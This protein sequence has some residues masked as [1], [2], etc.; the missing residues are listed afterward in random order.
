MPGLGL[1][2]GIGKI[3][4]RFLE[5]KT[6][7]YMLSASLK[8]RADY[9]ENSA[10][11][12]Q[13]LGEIETIQ[14][15]LLRKSSLIFTPTAYND[16]EALCVKPSDGS[17][18]F[19]VVRGSV[20]TRIN[21]DG[22]I[23]D[24]TT[25][26]S[27]LVSNGDFEQ[28]GSELITNGDF[29]TDTDWIKGT[30]T[31]ISGGKLNINANSTDDRTLQNI[32]MVQNKTYKI[33]FEISNY[34]GGALSILFGGSSTPTIGI[35]NSDG[36]YS[37]IQENFGANSFFYFKGNLFIGSIDNI[38][39]K[40]IGQDWVIENTWTIG[41]GVANGNGANGT[42]EELVQ[43][44]NLA[45]GKTY[46]I[47]YEIKNYVSGV[48]STR[49]PTTSGRS[50][51][52]V[53]TEIAVSSATA[54][55]FNG[56]NF[57]GS[58]TNI[59]I[60]EI[61]DDTNLPRIN[62]EDFTYQDILGSEEVTNG[63]FSNGSTDWVIEDAW[64][65]SGGVA[66]GNGADGGDEELEQS[67][68]LT[69]GRTYNVTYEVKNYVSG[70]VKVQ[71]P[72]GTPRTADGVYTEILTAVSSRIKFRGTNFDG[73]ITNISAKEVLGQEIVPDSG[74]GSW[75]WE[76]QSTNL[77]TSSEDFTNNSWSHSSNTIITSNVAVSPDGTQNA[78]SLVYSGFGNRL[79]QDIAMTIGNQY[80]L[81]IYYKNN[82][83]GDQ[84]SF[85]GADTTGVTTVTI[86]DEWARYTVILTATATVTSN[87]RF[88]SGLAN[89]NLF[90]WG[91]QIE[92]LSYATSYIPTS[93]TIATRLADLV[94]GAGD[95]N[96]FNSTEGVLYAE[97]AALANDGAVRY[98]GLSD[99][100]TNNRV[101]ILYYSATN[102]VRAIVSSGGTK[103]VDVNYQL[104][105]ILDFHKVAIKY[106]LNDFAFW[107]DG[108]EVA[109]DTSLNA[110]IVLDDLSFSIAAGSPF[111]GKT[112]T[113]A[114]FSEA[115]TDEE[116][117]Q[118]TTI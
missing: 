3:I 69:N 34:Q 2:I 54:L 84:V 87:L 99:G 36:S 12:E 51:N 103:Y 75:L 1:G 55:I 16:G 111:Y 67:G 4:N 47:T 76:P 10:S 29:A 58:I 94:T 72:T 77:I 102:K 88:M 106:K 37:F 66:I 73:S 71:K 23:E 60:K 110:P 40:E 108:V 56:L 83:G 32:G 57:N 101:I 62:Y 19:D 97:I 49:R 43:S 24:V 14:G 70:D 9:Y 53:Y 45:I 21:K 35:L 109:T 27:D 22:L 44:G 28:E 114:V 105:N 11:T 74:C 68:I 18:D 117:T 31:T 100:S 85:F 95:V 50:A 64:T 118:L 61:T 113:T 107:I 20:A 41:D 33:T 90:A 96:T 89:A 38:S 46:S 93:G 26:S 80:A 17:G 52:G 79:G 13:T 65:I 78:D 15:N 42:N 116:L 7:A 115:L 6:L 81:S 98:L 5:I 86:T 30:G 82:G 59:V 91:A 63:D 112:K 39:V 92:E 8:R 48:V 104:T 25:L